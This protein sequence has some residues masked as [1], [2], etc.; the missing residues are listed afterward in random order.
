MSENNEGKIQPHLK[1]SSSSSFRSTAQFHYAEAFFL[2]AQKR[3]GPL[4]FG[5]GITEA[6]VF[7]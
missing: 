1:S 5:G 2:A 6:Q 7:F 3:M 4:L